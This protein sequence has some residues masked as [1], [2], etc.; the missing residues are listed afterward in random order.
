MQYTP[1]VEFMDPEAHGKTSTSTVK[2]KNYS[3]AFFYILVFEIKIMIVTE[4]IDKL[5]SVIIN[6]PGLVYKHHLNAII[7]Y[8]T[9]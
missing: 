2:Q 8:V 5:P 9:K 3:F 6:R 1:S 7:D 4:M